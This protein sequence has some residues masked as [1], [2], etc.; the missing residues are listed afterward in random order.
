MTKHPDPYSP[1]L[2]LL[3][4]SS[5]PEEPIPL[6]TSS[7]LSNLISSALVQSSKANKKLDE[8]LPQLYTYLS[9]LAKSSDAG[10]Q[11]I[12]VQEYSTV[13]RTS[14]SRSQFWN[15]RGETLT[16]LFDILRSAS[17]SS[18]D[19]DST[20]WN[21]GSTIRSISDSGIGGGV[22]L[23][24]LYHVLL[25]IWQLSFEGSSVGEGLHEYVDTKM[26]ER[27]SADDRA[28]SRTL[29]SSTRTCYAFHQ[30]KKQ[31]DFC[32]E[33]SSTSYRH[34]HRSCSRLQFS[35]ACPQP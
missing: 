19:S 23:Q 4:Q 12:A 9:G 27:S 24:L 10:L 15:Q 3:K 5:N 2:P 1:F 26:S 7:L 32:L 6:L 21:G 20:L 22:G 17:G 31:L 18:R 35:L 33:H 14:R 34:L 25:V 28:G 13:L 16:P 11:D 30:R 8:A 29:S